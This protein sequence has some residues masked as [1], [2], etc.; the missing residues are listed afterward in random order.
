[1]DE[2]SRLFKTTQAWQDWLFRNHAGG[3]R[4]W[5][6]YSKKGPGKRS[7]TYEEALQEALCFGRIGADRYKQRFTPS[8]KYIRLVVVQ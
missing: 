5:L 4:I 2:A 3:N 8:K 7:V 1:M 6:A